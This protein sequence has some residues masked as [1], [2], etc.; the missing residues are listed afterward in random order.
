MGSKKINIAVI[1]AGIMSNRV[2]LPIINDLSKKG[3]YEKCVLCDLNVAAAKRSAEKFGFNSY[4]HE[5]DKIFKDENIDAVY[6][7]GT[8]LMHQKC[9]LMA[10][11]NNKHVFIEKPPG[12]DPKVISRVSRIAREKNLT[13]V[14]GF[15][16]R[17]QKNIRLAKS[18]MARF[19]SISTMEAIYNTPS[20]GRDIPFG[21]TSML[22]ANSIHSIDVLCYL[23]DGP[24]E[25]LYSS[26]NIIS[27][28]IPQNFSAIMKW[29]NGAH[30][31]IA[32]CN[33]A[34]KRRESYVLNGAAISIVCEELQYVK[35]VGGN[36]VEK[37]IFE[38]TNENRGFVDEHKAFAESI[39][40]GQIPIND[41]HHGGI[42]LHLA[43]LMEGG[44]HGVIDWTSV[45]GEIGLHEEK[46]VFNII[47]KPS[48]DAKSI[49][50]LN[51]DMIKV[52]LPKIGEKYQL[53]FDYNLS[54]LTENDK[55]NIVAIIEGRGGVLGKSDLI[56]D[57][58]S[59]K[60][61]GF[62]GGT[63]KAAFPE[64]LMQKNI[65]IINTADVAAD[66][67][68]EF[69]LMMMLIGMRNAS[70]SHEVMRTGNWGINNDK[71]LKKETLRKL[72]GFKVLPFVKMLKPVLL[73][74]WRRI[75]R[76]GI[77]VM[78]VTDGFGGS[79]L[80]HR[81]Q[82]G[83]LGYGEIS[84]KLISL[85]KPFNCDIMVHSEYMSAYEAKRLEVTK[86]DLIQLL[87]CDVV[88]I[89][90]GLSDRTLKSF[91]RSAINALKPGSVLVNTARGE[92]I[93]TEALIDRLKKK[94]IFA[95][96]D[97]FDREPLDRDNTLRKL[98][99][100]FLTSHISGSISQVYQESASSIVDKVLKYLEGEHVEG[101]VEGFEKLHNMT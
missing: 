70:R 75:N 94:D 82:I 95:C 100:V 27:G 85:L 40:N 34:G 80:L 23:A 17:F 22:T 11:E 90:R 42:A 31:I 72:S 60:V 13:A 56:D 49:L 45:Q 78:G 77:P 1:G 38:D 5:A 35:Y 63:V 66:A 68:A 47:S 33:T 53:V 65:K 64:K 57:F 39:L 91:D 10:V 88:S 69:T 79:N 28:D 92:I 99:N 83:L 30:A 51:P 36:D 62:L 86:A 98:P 58:P 55:K 43:Q 6:V 87:Q 25:E 26:F 29:N 97:V 44:Y 8:A 76:Q 46:Q 74:L 50:V 24:P 16:R 89:H 7:F 37:K 61:V 4:I 73:P 2:H 71:R 48:N 96:L 3:Y 14:V 67:V 93:D 15:N 20:L 18:E 81:A 9:A 59:L 54:S 41:I 32:S 84:K 19:S 101:I 52:A 12:L 21:G